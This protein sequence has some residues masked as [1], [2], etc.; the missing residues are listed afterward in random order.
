MIN[1]IYVIVIFLFGTIDSVVA[2]NIW[3][4]NSS[5]TNHISFVNATKGTF[6]T[7]ESNPEASAINSN[8]IVSKFVRDGQD[9]PNI[10]FNLTNPIMDLS[11]Y[12]ISLKAYTSISTADLNTTNS[13]IRLFLRNSNIGGASNLFLDLNFSGGETW[14][15]FSYDFTGITIPD[16]VVLAGGYDQ[17]LIGLA[18]GDSAG[19]TSTYYL[20]A[21][22]GYSEQ[23]LPKATLLSG[24]W[25]VRFNLSGGIRLDNTSD[26]DWIAGIQEVVD[27]LPAVSHIMT[28][29]THPAHGYYYTLRDNPYVD[30][31]E[32]IHPAMVP[33]LENEQII[34]DVIDVIKNSGKKVILYLNAGG[35]STLQGS[36]AEELEI[37]AAW[38]AYYNSKFDGDEGMAWRNLIRGYI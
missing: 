29:C 20:D 12:I 13:K 22:S 32:E 15:S 5:G 7:D 26:D 17:I 23:S 35:P 3:Y 28:N 2:Q 36:S 8:T 25:G 9:N 16:D 10:R 11:S 30:V 18:T 37:K 27:N 21:I 6:T 33:S 31:A 14:E 38:E 24:S 4:E 34:L 1:K 19:L